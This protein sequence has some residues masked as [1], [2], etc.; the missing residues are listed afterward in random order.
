MSDQVITVPAGLQGARVLVTGGGTG[1]GRATAL[2]FGRTGATVAVLGRHAE[3]LDTVVGELAAAGTDAM[4]CV[5]NI[6]DEEQV[7]A[8]FDQIGE[9]WGGVDVLVNNAGGQFPQPAIDMSV[10]AWRAVVDLNLTGTFIVSREFARRAVAE[11]R[12]GRIVNVSTAAAFRPNMGL[13]HSSSSRAGVLAQT[14]ALA[15]EWAKYGITVNALALGMIRTS[16]YVDAELGGDAD[17][18]D[19]L[20]SSVPLRR[21]GTPEEVAGVIA[22]M[23]SPTAAY[24]TG[25]T[26][27]LDG[28]YVLGPGTHF[29]EHGRFDV[30]VSF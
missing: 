21:V 26:I 22:F 4:A 1:I 29:G 10:N 11:A 12:P 23:A 28:G 14:Q 24:M 9:A 2:L 27:L 18:V 16:G 13:S 3:T 20:A 15:L 5:A 25:A 7:G 30:G 17:A 8:A 6:R 19:A